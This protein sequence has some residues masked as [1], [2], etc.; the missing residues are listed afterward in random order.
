MVVAVR[1]EGDVTKPVYG[2]L[3]VV[4]ACYAALWFVC[5]VYLLVSKYRMATGLLRLQIRYLMFAFAVPS[6]LIILTNLAV[7]LLVGS[8]I[9]GRYGPF[10]SLLSSLIGHAIIRHRLMDMRVVIRRSVV[11]LV[12]FG[13]AGLTLIT[14]LV[15]SNLLLHDQRQTPLREIVLALAIAV[16]FSPLKAQIQRAFDRYLYREPYDYQRTIRDA[17]RALGNTIELPRL[18]S[19]I[20]ARS[21]GP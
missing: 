1:F 19:Y 14:L 9:P 16:V 2:P 3:H 8:S 12:A 13:V 21:S 5:S 15:V 7:P 4:F 6:A 10:F 11:Y 20:T 18:L 17:S